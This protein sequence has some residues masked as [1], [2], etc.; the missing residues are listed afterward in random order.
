MYEVKNL[1]RELY[2]NIGVVYLKNMKELSKKIYDF[3]VEEN[4]T[5]RNKIMIDIILLKKD[6]SKIEFLLWCVFRLM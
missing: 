1:N 4:S 2:A 3:E 5:N 6:E